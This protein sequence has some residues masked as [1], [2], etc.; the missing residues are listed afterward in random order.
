M[1]V[2]SVLTLPLSFQTR[3]GYWQ[4]QAGRTRRAAEGKGLLKGRGPWTG[5]IGL[6]QAAQ[7]GP[8]GPLLF[9]VIYCDSE[10]QGDMGKALSIQC[11]PV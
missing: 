7:A 2:R 10:T 11:K 1:K 6:Q 8:A 5:Q 3:R 4:L 9:S